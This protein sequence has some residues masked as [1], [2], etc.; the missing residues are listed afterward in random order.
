MSCW[1][2]KLW[3][4]G[5]ASNQANPGRHHPFYLLW[6]DPTTKNYTKYN[7]L[8]HSAYPFRRRI[9]N[10]PRCHPA[11]V[12]RGAISTAAVYLFCHGSIDSISTRTS[13]PPKPW[14]PSSRA[15]RAPS[16]CSGPQSRRCLRRTVALFRRASG[17]AWT[18]TMITMITMS[19]R[20]RHSPWCHRRRLLRA[21]ASRRR[22]LQ[23]AHRRRSRRAVR[24]RPKG[25]ATSPERQARQ[26]IWPSSSLR[27]RRSRRRVSRNPLPV[28]QCLAIWQIWWALFA[29]MPAEIMLFPLLHE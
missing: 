20:G 15:R 8:L 6:H 26:R 16:P 21:A 27:R 13:R 14:R 25:R 24:R 10:L 23:A 18:M 28:S 2:T 9:H 29:A 22:R 3:H 12:H 4:C 11:L 19:L 7:P 17:S 5:G 1:L